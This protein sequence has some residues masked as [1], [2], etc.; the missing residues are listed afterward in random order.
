MSETLFFHVRE[1]K[2]GVTFAVKKGISYAGATEYE[3]GYSVSH[4]SDHFNK[5]TGRKIAT[6][7]LASMGRSSKDATSIIHSVI[8]D[9][10]PHKVK[11]NIEGILRRAVELSKDEDTQKISYKMWGFGKTKALIAGQ[12]VK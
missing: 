8:S 11:K 4:E 10:V 5:K 9:Y 6:E 1:G 12:F 7:R 3:V 2:R